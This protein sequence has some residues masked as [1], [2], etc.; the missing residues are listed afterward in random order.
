MA[1]SGTSYY[2]DLNTV[3][4]ELNITE[5]KWDDILDGMRADATRFI[6]D[7][8]KRTFIPTSSSG[9]IKYYDGDSTY[10]KIDDCIS[11]S[12]LVTDEDGDGVY[13]NTFNLASTSDAIDCYLYP[14]NNYPKMWLEINSNG[15][16]G[17]FA[18]GVQ[19]GVKI[20]GVW[21]YAA[22]VPRAID[23]ACLIQTCRWF[24][25]KDSAYATVIGEPSLGPIE[26]HQ[27]LDPDVKMLLKDYRRSIWAR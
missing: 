27:G 26:V 6:D 5:T 7:Y 9:T 2:C 25:R 13:E 16:F 15:D 18:T 10:L 24:K 8:C 11:I 21:G 3:K 1:E 17:G 20:T 23:R 4:A 12:A 14:L 19:R 22:S